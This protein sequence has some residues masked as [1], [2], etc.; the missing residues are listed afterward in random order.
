MASQGR[1]R[2][3]EE[4]DDD[5]DAVQ[6]PSPSKRVRRSDSASPEP[7]LHPR[8]ASLEDFVDGFW[9]HHIAIAEAREETFKNLALPLARIKK[10]MKSDPEVKVTI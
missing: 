2:G 6:R 5:Q 7:Y 4:D 9:T 10:V 1:R 3:N 8:D